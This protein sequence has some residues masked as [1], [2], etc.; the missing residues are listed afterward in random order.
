MKNKILL[1]VSMCM[2]MLGGAE[3]QE[4][5]CVG[6]C[7]SKYEAS[8]KCRDSSYNYLIK[9]CEDDYSF[10]DLRESLEKASVYSYSLLNS[11]EFMK[12]YCSKEKVEVVSACIKRVCVKP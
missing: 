6:Y 5:D 8:V 9:F 2:F 4:I 12:Y 1:I 10:N 7:M 3:S 11:K